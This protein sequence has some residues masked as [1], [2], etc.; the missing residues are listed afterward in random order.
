M[1]DTGGMTSLTNFFG[2][3]L[4]GPKP[5][6][7]VSVRTLRE[8][9]EEALMGYRRLDLEVVLRDELGLAWPDADQSPSD[10]ELSKRELIDAYLSGW[11]VP[12]LAAL[13]RRVTTE[14]EVPSAGLIPL[15]EAHDRGRGVGSPV[16]NLIFAA[17]GP[18][19]DLVL[20]DAVNNDVE[21]VTN[22]EFCLVYDKSVPEDGLRF[23]HLIDWWRTHEALADTASDRDVGVSLHRRL[24]ASLGTN[25]VE[26]KLFNAYGRRYRDSLDTHVLIP[27]VYLHYD[28]RTQRARHGRGPGPLARQRMDFLLLFSNRHRVVIEVDGKQHYSDDDGTAS[29]TRYGQMVAEDRRL[30]LAG[31]EVYRFGGAELMAPQADK[32][33]DDFFADLSSRRQ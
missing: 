8:G 20:R 5:A 13:A 1:E 11:G 18:K 16:K 30:Q 26:I 12:Q 29:P 25:P 2:E 14:L 22:G 31:Y 23:S 3:A 6:V 21:I 4:S 24:Q 19:P 15:L 32:M 10:P 7:Q 9:L 28:P 33:L 17:N 27:Q